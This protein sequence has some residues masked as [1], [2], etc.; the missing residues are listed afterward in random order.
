LEN[1]SARNKVYEF[2]KSHPGTHL[3]E[4][5]RELGLG[6]GDL[7]YKLYALEKEGAIKTVRRGLRKFIYPSAAFG[8]R[9]EMI[10]SVLAQ[11]TPREIVLRVIDHP[12]TTQANLAEELKLSRPAVL[13]HMKRLEGL[14][15]IVSSRRGRNAT[16]R[17]LGDV[18]QITDLLRSYHPSVWEKWANRFTDL[19]LELRRGERRNDDR[20]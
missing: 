16:Y 11:E 20:G 10:L 1:E 5:G 4:V 12:D 17:L 18:G 3:R 8:P 13:W 15:L 6:V 9:E 19:L 2:I 14:G 7:Q